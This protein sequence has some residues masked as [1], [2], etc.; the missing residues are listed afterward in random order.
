[1]YSKQEMK[2]LHLNASTKIN[3]LTFFF[4]VCFS[5]SLDAIKAL[6]FSSFMAF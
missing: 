3:M 6:T 2:N 4:A 1:M 5:I